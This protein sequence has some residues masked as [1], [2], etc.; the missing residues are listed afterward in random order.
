MGRDGRRDGR[1][2]ESDVNRIPVVIRA[3]ALA[4]VVVLP[5]VAEAQ[6]GQPTSPSPGPSFV[7]VGQWAPCNHPLAVQAG[8]GCVPDATPVSQVLTSAPEAD[9]PPPPPAQDEWE[10]TEAYTG[11]GTRVPVLIR[12]SNPERWFCKGC[13][14]VAPYADFKMTI[15]D[16]VQLSDGNWAWVGQITESGGTPPRGTLLSYPLY[17]D[18]G[19]WLTETEFA[20]AAQANGAR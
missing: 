11:V 5:G 2:G 7:W 20:V 4:A 16:R 17:G 1:Y 12:T 13:K 19:L 9:E 8:R 10:Y 18:R 14:Y 3:L 6:W 15:L